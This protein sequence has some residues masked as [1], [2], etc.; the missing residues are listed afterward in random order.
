MDESK[1]INV[2]KNVEKFKFN[3]LSCFFIEYFKI[4]KEI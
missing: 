4:L 3:S 1:I 2:F